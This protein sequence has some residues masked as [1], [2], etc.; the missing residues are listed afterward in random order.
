[1]KNMKT[2]LI[3]VANSSS[4]HF[5]EVEGLGKKINKIKSLSN[6]LGRAHP[7]DINADKQ[8]R[9][10]SSSGTATH[11]KERSVSPHRHQEQVWAKQLAKELSSY[12]TFEE[13]ALVAPPQFL[14]E[15]RHALS[16]HKAIEKLVVKEIAKDFPDTLTEAKMTEKL[17][18][19]FDLWNR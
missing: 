19:A 11:S 9:G 4:A 3:L 14:G 8:G 18:K 10:H 12:S 15:L 2:L 1:M 16:S 5:F 6:E 17:C 13:F 7:G